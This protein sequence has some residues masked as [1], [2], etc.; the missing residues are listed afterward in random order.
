MKTKSNKITLT[1]L[2]TYTYDYKTDE[3]TWYIDG[4]VI[5]LKALLDYFLMENCRITIETIGEE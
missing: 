1:G 5:D 4:E 3:Y 2:V